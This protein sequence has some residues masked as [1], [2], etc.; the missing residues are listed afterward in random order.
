ML[1]T[2]FLSL[3][4]SSVT[5]VL[6]MAHSQV[7]QSP[8]SSSWSRLG[9]T[10]LQA[11]GAGLIVVLLSACSSEHERAK[12]AT[13]EGPVAGGGQGAM[14]EGG[15]QGG[16]TSHEGGAAGMDD[17]DTAS[18]GAA[19]GA[20]AGGGAESVAGSGGMSENTAG[21]AG[22][23]AG[24]AGAAGMAGQGGAGVE[25]P[26]GQVFDMALDMGLGTNIGNTFD[27][28]LMWETG[29]GQPVVTQ[30]YIRGLAANGIKTVRVPVAWDTYAANGVVNAQHLARVREVVGWID[31]AGL[32]SIVNIHWDGGWIFNE[33]NENEYHLTED[34]KSK[35][36]SY[37]QQIGPAFADVG[38]HLILEGLNEEVRFFLDGAANKQPD[39]VAT[40]E[41]NQLFVSTIRELEG[42]NKTRALLI[43]GF[44]TNIELSCVDDFA[45][46]EDPAGPGNI[47]LSLHYY[48]PF[49]FA[50]MEEEESWGSPTTTW[51]SPAEEEELDTQFAIL[52]DCSVRKQMPI[53]LGEFAVTRGQT[54]VREPESRT[55]WM[56]AVMRSTWAR[57]GVPVLWDTDSEIS[58]TDG[59]FSPELQAAIEQAK[60]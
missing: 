37:W 42:F 2:T 16:T 31:D 17:P 28:T 36:V 46:P 45:V 23:T 33:N 4:G 20:A 34:V 15:G 40:N 54:F 38:H 58:R 41:L 6:S 19:S 51:G 7:A 32:Y 55:R 52:G 56:A 50:L 8:L 14:E 21:A 39:Y 48:T 49:T 59:S 9:V 5:M 43:A 24:S 44:Q 53:I 12:E 26:E 13:V 57:G 1:P 30:E 18:G 3:S 10:R 35:F 25:M 11:V 27:N 29:W 22:G 47:F 60:H